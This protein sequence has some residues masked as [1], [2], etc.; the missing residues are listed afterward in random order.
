MPNDTAPEKTGSSE[1]GDEAGRHGLPGDLAGAQ[2]RRNNRLAEIE[3]G[4]IVKRSPG[5]SLI[6][7]IRRC[8]ATAKGRGGIGRQ[9]TRHEKPRPASG[10][11]RGRGFHS[12]MA[13]EGALAHLPSQY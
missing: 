6:S 2:L 12:E 10:G 3:L 8:A 13:R 7:R 1:N 5:A 11:T 9:S 4:R